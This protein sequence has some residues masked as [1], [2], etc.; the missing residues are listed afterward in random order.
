MNGSGI[1]FKALLLEGWVYSASM[2]VIS[3]NGL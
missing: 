2:Y 1:W 3:A